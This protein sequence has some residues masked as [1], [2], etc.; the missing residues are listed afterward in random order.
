MYLDDIIVCIQKFDEHL[1]NLQHIL[2]ILKQESKY[3][4]S[5]P[6]YLELPRCNRIMFINTNAYDCQV[7][8]VLL[9]QQPDKS[10][11]H[12]GYWSHTLAPV[13]MRYGTTKRECLAVVW[14]MLILS[15]Y[16]EGI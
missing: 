6:P 14:E 8:C 11:R 3:K 10:V 4:L 5:S 12:I 13:K 2:R 7:G 15:P 9:K 1:G 16:L